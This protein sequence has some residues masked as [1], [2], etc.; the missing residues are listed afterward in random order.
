LDR[1]AAAR[2]SSRLLQFTADQDWEN[3]TD[4]NLLADRPRKWELSLI[5][6][7]LDEPIGYAI[8]SSPAPTNHHLHHIAVAPGMRGKGVGEQ[9]MRALMDQARSESCSLT[10]KVYASSAQAIRLYRRL[11]F[12][13]LS[14]NDQQLLMSI[15]P[16][17]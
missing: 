15:S 14:S 5:A 11:G 13:T 8:V 6:S 1:D 3:W 9:L 17:R 10:L 16:D 4:A 12:Q 2:F 7:S